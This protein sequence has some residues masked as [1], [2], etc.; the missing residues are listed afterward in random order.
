MAHF[1]KK[2]CCLFCTLYV[3]LLQICFSHLLHFVKMHFKRYFV[4][5]KICL[6]RDKMLI[7]SLSISEPCSVTRCWNEK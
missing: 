4:G 2:K 5:L 7:L 1:F 3:T 6:W